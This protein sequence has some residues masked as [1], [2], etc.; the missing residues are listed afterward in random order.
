MKKKQTTKL[1]QK[2]INRTIQNLAETNVS[3]A[4]ASNSKLT[5]RDK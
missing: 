1:D 4:Q 3:K 2:E 5:Q